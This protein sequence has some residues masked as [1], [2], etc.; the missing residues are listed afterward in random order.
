[1]N[2]C[3]IT[4][5]HILCL[6]YSCSIL[7]TNIALPQQKNNTQA[8]ENYKTD[9]IVSSTNKVKEENRYRGETNRLKET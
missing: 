7:T 8:V 5:S 1:M 2:L 3:N 4:E 9:D 6:L